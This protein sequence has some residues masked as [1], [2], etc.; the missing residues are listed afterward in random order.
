MPLGELVAA[1]VPRLPDS[2]G[3]VL[4]DGVKA[5]FPL[6]NGVVLVHQ[7][8]P[9]V[10]SFRWIAADSEQEYGPGTRYR[11]VRLA[12]PY[13][14][15]VAVFEQSARRA[16]PSLGSRNECFF[17]NQPLDVQGVETELCYPALLNCSRFAEDPRH[18][19]SWICTQHLRPPAAD[20]GAD[21]PERSLHAGL[22][23]LLHHLLES[24]F[25]RSSEHHELSSWFAESVKARI[26]PRIASVEDWE[27]A[28]AADPL[29]VLDVPW[30]RTGHTLAKVVERIPGARPSDPRSRPSARDLTRIILGQT[31]RPRRKTV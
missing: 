17:L 1:L 7:T 6:A 22:R 3:A 20:A 14:V 16:L 9:R 31:P 11:R 2:A 18:P 30:L 10:Y 25:N 4:P 15:V 27:Q 13:L 24:G 5:A 28:T 12:L 19:L 26:D 23:A 8:P 29:F 21:T